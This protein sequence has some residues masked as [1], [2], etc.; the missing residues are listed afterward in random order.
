MSSAGSTYWAEYDGLQWAKHQLLESYLEAW[1]PIM[2]TR[3]GR[4]LYIDSHAGRGRHET[5]HRGSP[6]LAL[7]LLLNHSNRERILSNAQC[8]FIFFESN[9][10]NLALLRE[11]VSALG[12]LP[13]RIKVTVLGGD[14]ESVL[15]QQ[16]SH[17]RQSRQV[18]APAFV[19]VDPFS[20]KLPIDLLNDLLGFPHCELLITFMFRYADMAVMGEAD[21]SLDLD[22]LF[23]TNA[24][25]D[26]RKIGD[27]DK[28][29][30]ATLELLS[31]QLRA[32]H[33]TT[34]QM[35]GKNGSLK[36]VLIH[37]SNN[38]KG[39]SKFKAAVW[40]VTPDGTF[41]VS[42]RYN[43][44]Q[45]ILIN[46]EPDLEPLR[47]MLQLEYGGK[48]LQMEELYKWLLTTMYLE[49]HL[50][51][52]IRELRKANLVECRG[53]EGRFAFNKNPTLKF[54]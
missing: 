32:K 15:I 49:K 39:R 7:E 20:F 53:Y 10:E 28:R 22:R 40:K 12:G 3:N 30:E 27:Y 14:Y 52:V 13:N 17:L 34:M 51:T 44:N 19:F 5:G 54:R 11:E 4:I 36:Y 6:I 42:E 25:T 43:P 47:R 29:I 45:L 21:N 33:V 38:D 18:L 9:P 2:A 50:H 16:I 26:L 48:S 37:A 46:P 31:H 24:W 23:G 1:F 35:K 8:Q 41:A